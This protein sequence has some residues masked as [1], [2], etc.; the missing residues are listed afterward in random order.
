MLICWGGIFVNM[1]G[2]KC[3]RRLLIL[4]ETLQATVLSACGETKYNKNKDLRGQA[5]H[6]CD[7]CDGDGPPKGGFLGNEIPIKTSQ[8]VGTRGECVTNAVETAN[9]FCGF[10]RN[11]NAT[12]P[13]SC[14]GTRGKCVTNAV[15][16]A[17]PKV[18]SAGTEMQ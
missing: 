9:N 2:Q 8:C 1:F 12:K 5:G 18:E 4:Q 6:M 3:W 17:H 14:V 15:E 16:T 11:S 13:S 10:S 7:E